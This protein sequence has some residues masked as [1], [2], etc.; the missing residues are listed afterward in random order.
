M[1][2]TRRVRTAVALALVAAPVTAAAA[3][4]IPPPPCLPS[5]DGKGPTVY[6]V[7]DYSDPTRSDVYYE[8]NGIGV[9]VDLCLG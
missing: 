5:V 6:V 3:A 4:A 8:S 9:E 7:P 1:R 2:T